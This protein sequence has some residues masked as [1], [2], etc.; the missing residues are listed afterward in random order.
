MTENVDSTETPVE[1]QPV[2]DNTEGPVEFGTPESSNDPHPV[3]EDAEEHIGDEQPD[4][5]NASTHQEQP[6]AENSTD[7]KE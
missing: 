3:D 5:W 1:E 4:P 7:A 6:A 2:V